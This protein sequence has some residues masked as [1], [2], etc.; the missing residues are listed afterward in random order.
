MH[1]G[2]TVPGVV[3]GKPISLGGSEGRNEATA[4]GAVYCIVEAGRHLGMDLHEG[5]GRGPG[6]RQRRLDRGAAH[7]RG[8]RD[9]RRRLA[10]RPAASTTRTGST[11]QRVIAW[12]K[13]ARHGP[14]L[15]RRDR[16]HE[17][18]GPRGRLRHPHPGRPREP[19]HRAQ[20]RQ[21]QGQSS[22]PRPPT[23]RR[24]PRPTRSCSRTGMFLIPDILCNAGGVTVSYFEWVQDLNRD[25]WSETRRQRQAQGDHGQGV[26]RD[27]RDRQPR[28]VSTCGP[29]PTCSRSSAS[30][31]PRR[32]AAST[33]SVPG[34]DALGSAPSLVRFSRSSRALRLTRR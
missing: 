20:R 30:P 3:T 24:R 4:R 5:A 33:R 23:A 15:P 32:C 21:D 6:L 28:A 22:S 7:R 12:K 19:D 17:R 9:R 2:Y 13:R 11:S 16:R 18:G 25:H 34:P 31:T 14:G 8:G 29:P 27:P 10:T 26:Q 1:A